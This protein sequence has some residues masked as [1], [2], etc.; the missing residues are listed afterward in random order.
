VRRTQQNLCLE[1]TSFRGA[2]S[3]YEYLLQSQAKIELPE[4]GIRIEALLT[5]KSNV[6]ET[7]SEHL[8]DPTLCLTS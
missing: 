8:L 7:E 3:D 2:P 4:L 5:K 6:P 1:P